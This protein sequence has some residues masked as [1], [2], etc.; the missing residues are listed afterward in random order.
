[1]NLILTFDYELFGSG[2]GEVFKHLVKPTNYIL[3]TLDELEI[4]ATFF[5]EY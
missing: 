1:M 2:Q 3:D 4:K 5:I